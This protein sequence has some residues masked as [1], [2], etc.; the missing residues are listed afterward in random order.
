MVLPVARR[1]FEVFHTYSPSFVTRRWNDG[2]VPRGLGRHLRSASPSSWIIPPRKRELR[3]A[4]LGVRLP[5]AL[6]PTLLRAVHSRSTSPS[7]FGGS[8]PSVPSRSALVVFHHLGGL[9][10]TRS[11]RCIAT[12]YRTGFATFQPRRH[13]ARP[14]GPKAWTGSHGHE[15]GIPVAPHPSKNISRRQPCRIAAAVA[16]MPLPSA[17]R[18]HI[19]AASPGFVV[20]DLDVLPLPVAPDVGTNRSLHPIV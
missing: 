16:L 8:L 11:L 18:D 19:A 14:P 3:S 4:S 12:R 2:S 5:G 7:T 10:R 9:L 17:S 6:P 20:P 15:T 13:P 1:T